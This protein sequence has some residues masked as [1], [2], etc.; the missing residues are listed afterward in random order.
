MNKHHTPLR[1]YI[2]ELSSYFPNV[3]M[4]LFIAREAA[5]ESGPRVGRLIDISGF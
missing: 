2:F 3:Q 4:D 1:M 5:V